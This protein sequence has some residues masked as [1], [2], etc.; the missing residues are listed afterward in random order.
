M[1]NQSTGDS[2]HL[3]F[4][5]EDLVVLVFFLI[6][7]LLEVVFRVFRGQPLDPS[8]VFIVIPA[9]VIVLVKEVVSCLIPDK[10]ALVPPASGSLRFAVAGWQ[11]LRDWFPLLMGLLMYYALW[12]DTTLM[13]VHHNRDAMLLAWDKRLFGV[14]PGLW[15]QRFVSPP[16]TSWMDFSYAFHLYVIPLVAAFIYLFRPLKRFREMM[17][18][19]VVVSFIGMLGY[20]AVPAVGPMYTLHGLYTAPLTQPIGLFSRPIQFMEIARIQRDCFPSLHVG[21]SFLVWLYAWRNSK[22]LFWILSPFILSLWVSTVYLRFHYAVDCIAGFILAPLCYLLANW[23]YSKYADLVVPVP[24]LPGWA[25]RVRRAL[26]PG[27]AG[28]AIPHA[29]GR[30]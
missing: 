3:P 4:R 23:L 12:G 22:T 25:S 10:D 26:R 14:D 18:G 8:A 7:L 29:E 19:V 20:L 13:I 6:I 30:P 2:L 21:I 1:P 17:T 27:D 16:L 15:I 5:L 11:F 24:L 28:P 9:I